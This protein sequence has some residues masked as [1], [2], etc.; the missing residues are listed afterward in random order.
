MRIMP[1]NDPIMSEEEHDDSDEEN[2]RRN[3]SRSSGSSPPSSPRIKRRSSVSTSKEGSIVIPPWII[4]LN[5]LIDE[6]YIYVGQN[7]KISD[8][9]QASKNNKYHN[10]GLKANANR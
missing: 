9:S 10:R 8:P 3:R 4:K 2:S 1:L 6:N 5:S 7:L